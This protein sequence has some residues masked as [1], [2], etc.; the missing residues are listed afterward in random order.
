MDSSSGI[1][2]GHRI[3]RYIPVK[4]GYLIRMTIDKTDY[5]AIFPEKY[6]RDRYDFRSHLSRFVS[7][8]INIQSRRFFLLIYLCAKRH[9][10]QL[11]QLKMLETKRYSDNGNAQRAAQYGMFR[12]KRQSGDDQPDD[13]YQQRNRPASVSYFLP[14]RKETE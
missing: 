13:I 10:R 5:P 3:F 8:M 12:C 7:H 9:Q 4:S 1:Q 6:N 14:E 2:F 11:S